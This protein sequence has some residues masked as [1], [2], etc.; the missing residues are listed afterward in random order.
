V[1]QRRGARS[2]YEELSNLEEKGVNLHIVT[3]EQTDQLSKA[4]EKIMKELLVR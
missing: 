1:P 4:M 2:A 3:A